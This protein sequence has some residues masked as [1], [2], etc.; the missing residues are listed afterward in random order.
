MKVAILGYTPTRKDAPYDDPAWEIWGLNDLYKFQGEG[1]VERWTRWFEMHD[2]RLGN[3]VGRA[4]FDERVKEFAKWEN[5]PIYMQN[6]HPGVSGS[7][8][9]PLEEVVK[10]YGDYFTNTISYMIALAIYEG[11]KEIGVYGVDMSTSEEYQKQRPS[12]EY[13]L[14]I[15]VG[16]GIKVTIHPAA[17]LLKTRYL[18]GYETEKE[19]KFAVKVT[20]MMTNMQER[21]NQAEAQLEEVKKVI[22]Q[23][24]GALAT[25]DEIRKLWKIE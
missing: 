5:I 3:R 12:C 1:D 11:A 8:A 21:K 22:W 6:K 19:E 20:A 15:A 18:Y 16:K 14:G 25:A 4:K 9:Y 24:D 13:Y 23:Y 7:V 2:D 17:D 10:Q